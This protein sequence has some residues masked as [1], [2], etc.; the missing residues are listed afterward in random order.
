M[1]GE[2]S[3]R[4]SARQWAGIIVVSVLT[5]ILVSWLMALRAS[6]RVSPEPG[7]AHRTE[8]PGSAGTNPRTVWATNWA[9]LNDPIPNLGTAGVHATTRAKYIARLESLDLSGDD[10][11]K[12]LR[13]RLLSEARE[14]PAYDGGPS[15][16]M[17][18][19]PALDADFG[20]LR[21]QVRKHLIEVGGTA[22]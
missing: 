6:P 11:L 9:N 20:E 1:S 17:V 7:P 4:V 12:A 14:A 2:E 19:T 3:P 13:D 8:T 22:N 10:S 21:R 5:S 16:D 18:V 15:Y